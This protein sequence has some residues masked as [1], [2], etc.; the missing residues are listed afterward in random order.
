MAAVDTFASRASTTLL[1]E[2]RWTGQPARIEGTGLLDGTPS[3]VIP[4]DPE[5]RRQLAMHRLDDKAP[6]VDV[7]IDVTGK[8]PAHL[9][10]EYTTAEE[11]ALYQQGLANG[12]LRLEQYACA[13]IDG[14][15]QGVDLVF[16]GEGKTSAVLRIYVQPGTTR[17]YELTVAHPS[18]SGKHLIV[19][20]GIA[21]VRSGADSKAIAK[22]LA[23]HGCSVAAVLP[24]TMVNVSA[25]RFANGQVAD[26][27]WN[28]I[29]TINH[30]TGDA[31]LLFPKNPLL[32]AGSFSF[33]TNPAGSVPA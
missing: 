16:S 18:I 12:T 1:P 9:V 32:S 22:R 25:P 29:V 31:M 13:P 10:R 14:A 33:G 17:P 21:L 5:F 3:I 11:L 20:D 4:P 30:K 27:L 8:K 26:R 28:P 19:R 7:A 6:I 15:S 24:E 2:P 23:D